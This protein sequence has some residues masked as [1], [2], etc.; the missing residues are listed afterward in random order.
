VDCFKV[1]CGGTEEN[2]DHL[3]SING[4]MF[5]GDLGVGVAFV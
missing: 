3:E 5:T 2:L 1:L 4:F